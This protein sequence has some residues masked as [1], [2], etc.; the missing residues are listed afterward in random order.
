MLYCYYEVAPFRLTDEA[1]GCVVPTVVG[2]DECAQMYRYAQLRANP[3]RCA[4]GLLW[5]EVAVVPVVV[6]M[7]AIYECQVKSS[8]AGAD[9]VE[10]FANA[11]VATV[12]GIIVFLSMYSSDG[13]SRNP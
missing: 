10:V 6:I 9:L 8:E 12:E 11:A 4:D 13:H 2:E 3:L 5:V 7:S 1:L